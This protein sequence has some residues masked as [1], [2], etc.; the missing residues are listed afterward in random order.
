MNTVA[1]LIVTS[2]HLV[3]LSTSMKPTGRFVKLFRLSFP[4]SF[5]LVMFDVLH[6]LILVVVS[7]VDRF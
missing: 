3:A 5:I 6:F 4:K 1:A 7:N 2:N